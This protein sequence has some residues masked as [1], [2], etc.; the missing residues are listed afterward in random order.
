MIYLRLINNSLSK[1][2][3]EAALTCSKIFIIQ[4][5]LLPSQLKVPVLIHLA[6]LL[7]VDLTQAE[8]GWVVKLKIHLEWA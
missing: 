1:Q 7:E 5:Q 6:L 4:H 2:V 3:E 8:L